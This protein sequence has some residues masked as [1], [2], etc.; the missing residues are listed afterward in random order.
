MA[1]YSVSFN[2]DFEA[3]KFTATRHPENR[4][5]GGDHVLVADSDDVCLAALKAAAHAEWCAPE[6]RA[7][8]CFEV[9]F[10]DASA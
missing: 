7:H 8:D 2:G 4:A 3:G 6:T 10:V 1:L 9:E 5:V